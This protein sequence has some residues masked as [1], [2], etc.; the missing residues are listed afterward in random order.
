MDADVNKGF[1][2]HGNQNIDNTRIS[3]VK[4]KEILLLPN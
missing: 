2:C 1:L 4:C 3:L